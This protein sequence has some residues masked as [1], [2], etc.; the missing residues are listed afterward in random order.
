MGWDVASHLAFQNGKTPVMQLHSINRV[1]IVVDDHF[2]LD[3]MKF[4]LD[5]RQDGKNI[6]TVEQA[7]AT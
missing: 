7:T 5:W 2:F 1:T 4:A 6:S 3:K